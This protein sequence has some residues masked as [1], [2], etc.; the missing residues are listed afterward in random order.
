MTASV[1]SGCG[2][3]TDSEQNRTSGQTPL[4]NG[5]SFPR[6]AGSSD[7]PEVLSISEAGYSCH[8]ACRD[9]YSTPAI[10][11]LGRLSGGRNSSYAS[12]IS[13]DGKVVVGEVNDGGDGRNRAFK[14]T[15]TT[16]MV[17]L[18]NMGWSSSAEAVN[19]DGSVIVGSVAID[20]DAVAF[21]WSTREGIVLLTDARGPNNR[22]AAKGVSADGSVVVGNARYP[23]RWTAATGMKPMDGGF[24]SYVHGLSADGSR[25]VGSSLSVPGEGEHMTAVYWD[26][27]GHMHPIGRFK[28]T[29]MADATAVNANGQWVA[30]FAQ[31]DSAEK[32]NV[33]FLWSEQTGFQT[34]GW[35]HSGGYARA[36]GIN[37]AGTVVVGNAPDGAY[38]GH[39][40]GF[41]WTRESGMQSITE[42]VQ[43]AGG[44][45]TRSLVSQV[46]GVSGDGNTIVGFLHDGDPFVAVAPNR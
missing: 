13:E 37:S 39:D 24:L 18:S 30:G 31:D 26:A 29:G 11:D 10:L 27:D 41:R 35:L 9:A 20:G 4:P 6:I 1:A 32:H 5:D 40:T 42:W 46:T 2:A 22:S 45:I 7:G 16:G 28:N 15:A 21:R 44:R 3:A 14:W 23:F 12:A 36:Y 8:I 34:L 43:A 19:A 25:A 33:A 17:S 38:H